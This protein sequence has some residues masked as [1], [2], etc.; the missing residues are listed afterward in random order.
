MLIATMVRKDVRDAAI[1]EL[2]G[3]KRVVVAQELE[4]M[5]ITSARRYA[6]RLWEETLR[7]TR[8]NLGEH[9]GEEEAGRLRELRKQDLQNFE[10][11]ITA[12]SKDR[13][14]V[15]MQMFSNMLQRREDEL[16]EPA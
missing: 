16:Y 12:A 6:A 10:A 13:F 4:T 8:N 2:E 1:A 7:E 11:V 14:K 9:F 3:E 5:G 15:A